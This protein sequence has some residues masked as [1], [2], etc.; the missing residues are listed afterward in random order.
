MN[1]YWELLNTPEWEEKRNEILERDN[2]QCQ[3]CGVEDEELHVH[4]RWYK[5]N[6]M[7]WDYPDSCYAT[8]CAQCHEH[9]HGI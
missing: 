1:D 5:S 6:T 3:E 7:P 2:Y 9:R 4:H 8:L